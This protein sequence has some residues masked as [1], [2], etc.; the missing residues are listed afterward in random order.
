MVAYLQLCSASGAMGCDGIRGIQN[1]WWFEPYIL[2]M[3]NSNFSPVEHQRTWLYSGEPIWFNMLYVI[4]VN[5]N[6]W[7]LCQSPSVDPV[8]LPSKNFAIP[9]AKKRRWDRISSDTGRMC[10][11]AV[12]ISKASASKLASLRWQGQACPEN[13]VIPKIYQNPVFVETNCLEKKT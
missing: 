8:V 10:S 11:R 3:Y 2:Y 5:V 6:E 1:C 9:G 4:N 13:N 7:H 12:R